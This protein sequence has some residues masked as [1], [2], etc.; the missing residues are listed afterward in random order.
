MRDAYLDWCVESIR[1]KKRFAIFAKK[2]CKILF[3]LW[4]CLC[5]FLS[6]KTKTDFAGEAQALFIFLAYPGIIVWLII[7]F[8]NKVTARVNKQLEALCLSE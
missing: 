4:V 8:C 6:V 2:L 3:F 5:L 1:V 7:K